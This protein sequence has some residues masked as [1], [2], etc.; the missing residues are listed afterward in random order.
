MSSRGRW[1]LAALAA[2]G[3]VLFV[4]P[5]PAG[6]QLPTADPLAVVRITPSGAVGRAV[7]EATVQFSVPMAAIEAGQTVQTPAYLHL[8]PAVPVTLR[9]ASS[10]V[11]VISPVAG[12]FPYD[13]RFT[14]RIDAGARAL[15]G[16]RLAA[17]VVSTFTT[18]RPRV[19]A[20][21]QRRP[22]GRV[23]VQ[24]TSSQPLRPD[25]VRAYTTLRYRPFA[26]ARRELTPA[27]RR[28]LARLDPAAP[29]RLDAALRVARTRAALTRIVP[30][31]PVEAPAPAGSPTSLAPRT[32]VVETVEVP[33]PGTRILAGPVPTPA[34]RATADTG[35]D[36]LANRVVVLDDAFWIA[37]PG[38]NTLCSP[39]SVGLR[40]SQPIDARA[41]RRAVRVSDVTT[42][43]APRVLTPAGLAAYLTEVTSVD[44]ET[45]GYTLA[46]GH[47]YEIVV[48]GAL[49]SRSG[50]RLPG[51]WVEIVDVGLRDAIATVSTRQAAVF[52]A[53]LGPRLPTVARS[54]R[55]VLA[56]VTPV[57]PDRVDAAL[58]NLDG[59]GRSAPTITTPATRVTV[60]AEQAEPQVA[61]VDASPAL[62]A[63]GT[64]VVWLSVRPGTELPGI[65]DSA[66]VRPEPLPS[67]ALV[68]V[69]NLGLT[70]RSL[71]TS[72]VVFVT[73]LDTGEPVAGA[74]VTIFD[75]ARPLW[76]GV[77]DARG[78][79][80]TDQGPVEHGTPRLVVVEHQGDRAY[81]EAPSG[82]LPDGSRDQLAGVV[83]TDRGIYRPGDTVT[84]KAI[85]RMRSPSG[86]SRLPRDTPITLTLD[87]DGERLTTVDGAIGELGGVEW[88]LPIAADAK[89]SSDYVLTVHRGPPPPP[90]DSR[91]G[92][93]DGLSTGFAVKE[94]RPLEFEA[95][96]TL[97]SQRTTGDRSGLELA[98]TAR[99]L[100]GVPLSRAAVSWRLRY[101]PTLPDV[102]E[103]IPSLRGFSFGATPDGE[104]EVGDGHGPLEDG[105]YRA[106]I[107]RG[108]T[109]RVA[110]TYILEGEVVDG[111]S[112]QAA[113]LS[114]VLTVR[115]DVLL[116]LAPPSSSARAGETTTVRVVAVDPDGCLVAGVP[117]TIVVPEHEAH[118][119]TYTKVAAVTGLDPVSVVL[120]ARDWTRG[121]T[122]TVRGTDPTRLSLATDAYIP[123][124]S[125]RESPKGANAP[126]VTL[127]LDKASYRIGDRARVSVAASWPRATALV[128][129]ERDDVRAVHVLA[130]RNEAQVI[131]VPIDESAV[132]GLTVSVVAVKGRT[133]PCCAAD[134][135][136]P[137]A[138]AVAMG[139]DAIAVDPAASRLSV[140]IDPGAGRPMAG[141]RAR[142]RVV[143]ADQAGRPAP[144][145]EV[146][147]WAVDEGWLRHIGYELPNLVAGLIDTLVPNFGTVDSRMW[148]L[149]R[150]MPPPWFRTIDT[151]ASQVGVSHQG[152]DGPVR[153]D[154]RP[155]AFW[156][157]A[158]RTDTAGAV[159]VETTLPDTL[160][161]Y[162]VMVVAANRARFG[163]AVQ[164]LVV[165]KPMML[166]T[167]L[168][169]TLSKG[170]RATVRIT[171]ASLLET[172][173]RGTLS[174]ESLTPDLLAIEGTPPAVRV[175]PGA[176]ETVTVAV[177]ALASG[178]ARV[179]VRVSSAEGAD[180]LEL[181]VP[182]A[183]PS[184][185]ER[186]ASYGRITAGTRESVRVPSGADTAAGGLSLSLSTSLLSGVS[187]AGRESRRL[188]LPVPRAADLARPGA[189]ALGQGKRPF[190]FH[191]GRTFEGRRGAGARAARA[192]H[193]PLQRSPRLR[194]LARR[195]LPRLV[196][197]SCGLRA[198]R[199]ARGPRSRDRGRPGRGRSCDRCRRGVA[200]RSQPRHRRRAGARLRR[201]ARAGGQG[202]GRRGPLPE[203]GRRRADRPSPRA[204][205]VGAR[206]SLRR[207][208][209]GGAWAS[210]A[211]GSRAEAAR[212]D[213]AGRDDGPRDRGP[214]LV[215]LELAVRRQVDRHRPRRAGAARRPRARDGAGSRHLAV[216]R[217]AGGHLAQ[218][219]GERLGA[220][221]AGVLPARDRGR[222]NRAGHGRRQDRINVADRRAARWPA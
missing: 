54:L 125:D 111:A 20:T 132:G 121:Y 15:S 78:V 49:T 5:A 114:E 32:Y 100:T 150:A 22:D 70:V 7:T 8:T 118:G 71:A 210:C 23:V 86:V 145:S 153:S 218:H 182:V 79:A 122:V 21:G 77:T 166:R 215:R 96:A 50:A 196:T 87:R 195:R 45:L 202:A 155:L 83:F 74:S 65:A 139:S 52:E 143:V 59:P 69:T 38:C 199:A 176:R 190:R 136:D 171:V 151:M 55:D 42:P 130:L 11:L 124:A 25:D 35:R 174:V 110:G 126:S 193:L 135:A 103:G 169:R 67:T 197:V 208:A 109:D 212:C 112:S 220:P 187:L 203:G 161:T 106:P 222:R 3:V 191:P 160:T 219:P 61:L 2:C 30:A 73:A 158:L 189:R 194:P 167:A 1:G 204:A 47:R 206:A 58:A 198:L 28:S 131:E 184:V 46:A 116:G 188:Q 63:N 163:H 19:M 186:S 119:T 123:F 164:P 33:P 221:R 80:R 85:L 128:T 180:A 36:P 137:G 88:T 183:A 76:R 37:G 16:A 104:G 84:V 134:G 60:E 148:L 157:G 41:L 56:S 178:T 144:S 102:H 147:L 75:G 44:L 17:P 154:M 93:R 10:S 205:G 207:P 168:P 24:I 62:A 120:P 185:V 48:D 6:A 68:Q 209:P 13:R 99:D 26:T 53:K 162:R 142:L 141:G 149:R 94:I 115:P 14:I 213:H 34:E 107:T 57:P 211:A 117:V 92:R 129:I 82:W 216:A 177:R 51:P 156:F 217:A 146:T 159:E 81:A 66:T 31:R 9:W 172:A 108:A 175:A 29:A 170:D 179:R 43:N 89:L 95:S 127:T 27:A 173:T 133:G 12:A 39:D 64:G 200:R 101:L 165:T 72:A 201:L 4:S 214:R 192:R 152:D 140:T 138:P 91:W 18:P 181:P 40:A 98:V 90:E 97:T 105:A 113:R